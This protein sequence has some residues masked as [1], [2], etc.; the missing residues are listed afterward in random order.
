MVMVF[1]SFVSVVEMQRASECGR[2][3]ST[4]LCAFCLLIASGSGGCACPLIDLAGFA[5]PLSR[6]PYSCPWTGLAACLLNALAVCRASSLWMPLLV[7]CMALATF[8]WCWCW[9]WRLLPVAQLL[10][11][12]ASMGLLAASPSICFCVDAPSAI[13][14]AHSLPASR[15]CGFG[16]AAAFHCSPQ[17]TA[18]A[19][20]ACAR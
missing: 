17:P 19:S 7:S 6:C 9:C 8:L 3:R 16:C 13:A 15:D 11:A 5:L 2:P 10:T 20:T 1:A 4:C 18:A 12:G 14:L